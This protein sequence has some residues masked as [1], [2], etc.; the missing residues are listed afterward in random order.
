M[1]QAFSKKRHWKKAVLLA[2]AAV[3]AY[4]CSTNWYQLMLV[5]GSSMYPAYRDMQPVV[6][7]KQFGS[8]HAGE[9]AAFWC[10]GLHALL[11][12]RVAAVPG[13]TV[14]VSGGY[15]YVNGQRCKGQAGKKISYAGIASVPLTLAEGEYFM[16]GDNYGSSKDSRHKEVGCAKQ[17]D[18]VG[19]V[20]PARRKAWQP[21]GKTREKE[22]GK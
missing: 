11:V 3:A 14:Q 19:R 21:C 13:D 2:A 17:K 4:S 15:L 9:V 1:K 16:L 18:I 6:L 10:E 8:L 5:H 12:K 20:L 7:E 22:H